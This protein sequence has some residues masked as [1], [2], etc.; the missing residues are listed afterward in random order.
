M[1]VRPAEATITIDGA[2]AAHVSDRVA[3]RV[4]VPRAPGRH[5]I[6][7]ALV[8]ESVSPRTPYG[9]DWHYT[10]RLRRQIVTAA[11]QLDVF[12]EQR[13]RAVRDDDLLY[14]RYSERK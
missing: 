4:D 5:V 1:L 9:Y 3:T 11:S 10:F 13:F 12:V 8:Y 14:L 6:V 7:V 2:I